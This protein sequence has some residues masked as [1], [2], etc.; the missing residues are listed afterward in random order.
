MSELEQ[1]TMEPTRQVSGG[2]IG[3]ANTRTSVM[4]DT[5]EET[6]SQEIELSIMQRVASPTASERVRQKRAF[7]HSTEFE[8]HFTLPAESSN[9][10]FRST[11]NM[12]KVY[13]SSGAQFILEEDFDRDDYEK[14]RIVAKRIQDTTGGL[15]FLRAI[16]SLFC[17][18]FLGFLV[19]FCL[20]LLLF[21]I[22]DL[23]IEVGLTSKGD[24]HPFEAVGCILALPLYVVGLASSLVI[25]GAFV[26]DTWKGTYFY[27]T[28]ISLRFYSRGRLCL[29]LRLLFA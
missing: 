1:N 4:T 25:A 11:S 14:H 15:R 24:I 22:S 12:A 29:I 10:R 2:L 13:T 21:L 9:I 28:C 17:V 23:T 20:Q 5:L 8:D 16:Y 19:I 18:F 27:Y 26:V 3:L 7:A 6:D